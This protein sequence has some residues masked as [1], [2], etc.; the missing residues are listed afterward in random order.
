MT[1]PL[2]LKQQV[3]KKLLTSNEALSQLEATAASAEGIWLGGI[4]ALKQTRTYKWL[5][6]RV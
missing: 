6:S 5:K 1:K 2:S 4:E 3:K